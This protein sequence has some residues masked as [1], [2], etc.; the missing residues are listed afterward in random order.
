MKNQYEFMKKIFD[1]KNHKSFKDIEGELIPKHVHFS[2]FSLYVKVFY[3][4]FNSGMIVEKCCSR[5]V[6]K[7]MLV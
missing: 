2:K 4:L 1:A 7:R 3:I 6:L 5:L